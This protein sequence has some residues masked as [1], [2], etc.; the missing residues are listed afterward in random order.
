MISNKCRTLIPKRNE[1]KFIIVTTFLVFNLEEMLKIIRLKKS[2][3]Q[4]KIYFFVLTKY[5]KFGKNLLKRL[6]E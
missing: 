3:I 6:N 5:F 1:V 4:T 2:K